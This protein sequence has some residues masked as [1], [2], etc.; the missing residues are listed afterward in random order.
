MP[1]LVGKRGDGGVRE[2]PIMSDSRL[3]DGSP[4][5]ALD[6]EAFRPLVE[7]RLGGAVG[8]CGGDV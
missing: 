8:L 2:K 7:E 6:E 4:H 3:H 5:D 1:S